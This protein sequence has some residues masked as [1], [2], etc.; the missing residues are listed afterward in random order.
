M[1][2]K[3]IRYSSEVDS[4]CTV[5]VLFVQLSACEALSL[6]HQEQ[7][8]L[9]K[10]TQR[11]GVISTLQRCMKHAHIITQKHT[12]HLPAAFH[13]KMKGTARHCLLTRPRRGAAQKI[14]LFC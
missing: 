10:R 3:C 11:H 4:F 13:H 6:R 12:C 14:S 5:S 2:A 7:V 8:C 9:R 1:S